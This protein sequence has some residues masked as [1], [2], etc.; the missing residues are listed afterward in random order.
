MLESPWKVLE[1]FFQK[2]VRALVSRFLIVE[3]RM[4][5]ILKNL[6]YRVLS[7][8]FPLRTELPLIIA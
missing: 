4:L 6:N 1:F 5:A 2:R 8:F 7:D 3:N